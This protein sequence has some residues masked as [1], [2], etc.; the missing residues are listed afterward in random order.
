[1]EAARDDVGDDEAG[2]DR[3]HAV[4]DGLH[5][6]DGHGLGHAIVDL[7]I[8]D[9]P[10]H[11]PGLHA[12]VRGWLIVD[13][14]IERICSLERA[15]DADDLGRG[16]ILKSHESRE[17]AL[18]ALMHAQALLA[19]RQH[20]LHIVRAQGQRPD[21]Q[22]DFLLDFLA[23]VGDD[24]RA[25]AAHIEQ[26]TRVVRE[27]MR[28]A[29]KIKRGLFL[30][31]DHAD[32]QSRACF[33]CGNGLLAVLGIAQCRRREGDDLRDAERREERLEPLQHLRRPV[34]ALRL[35]DAVLQVARESNELLFLHEHLHAL[36]LDEIDGQ[37]H[38]IRPDID[39]PVK[40]DTPHQSAARGSQAIFAIPSPIPYSPPTSVSLSIRQKIRIPIENAVTLLYHN[41]WENCGCQRHPR[42]AVGIEA[43]KA[44]TF[45]SSCLC[46]FRYA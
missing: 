42:E 17:D 8:L 33:E 1:M 20:P 10:A 23:A 43:A 13:E 16:K 22:A 4:R 7:E 9:E 18:G 30:A 38:R 11:E 3:V 35:H 46:S 27:I 24:F 31:R 12:L 14:V 6:L 45:G 26:D 2:D 15:A 21:G 19:Q 44:G 34:D 32:L 5:E 25:A 28:R 36:P 40:H 37:T 29:D 39:N 41:R